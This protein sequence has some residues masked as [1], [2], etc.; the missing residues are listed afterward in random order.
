MK[1]KHYGLLDWPEIKDAKTRYQVSALLSVALLQQEMIDCVTEGEMTFDEACKHYQ[2]QH[3]L[4]RI[5]V[6]QWRRYLHSEIEEL[7]S[8]PKTIN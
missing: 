6:R 1:K 2:P 4:I 7:N 5:I 8:P 3:K